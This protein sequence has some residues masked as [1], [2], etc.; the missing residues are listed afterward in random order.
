MYTIVVHA[1]VDH[2]RLH[3]D[4]PL[5]VP[6]TIPDGAHEIVL[7]I[8]EPTVPA[9]LATWPEGFFEQTYGALADDPLQRP[10]QAVLEE[11]EPL[12]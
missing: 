2:G 11:R 10:A 3:I 7:T 4:S 9:L 6:T 8:A 12:A 1:R 5:V